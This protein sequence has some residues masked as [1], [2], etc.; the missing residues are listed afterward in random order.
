MAKRNRQAAALRYLQGKDAAPRLVAKGSGAVAERILEIARHHG[1][2]IR[3]DRELVQV[4]AS[5]DLYR[6]IPP[7][8]YK[9]VAEILAFLYLLNR[10]EAPG[11]S[12]VPRAGG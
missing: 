7:E 8:L 12:A 10:G 9:A 5:L 3:E 2:P 1:I 4:L 11:H 6:E